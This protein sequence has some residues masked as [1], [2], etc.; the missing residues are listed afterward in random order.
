MASTLQIASHIGLWTIMI[1]LYA[2]VYLLYRHVALQ[3]ASTHRDN[4][5][6]L[7][8]P[9]RFNLKTIDGTM[10]PLGN[11]SKPHVLFFGEQRCATCTKMEPFLR[12]LSHSHP[13]ITLVVVYSGDTGAAREFTAQMTNDVRVIAD[14]T[15]ELRHMWQIHAVPFA[16]VTDHSGRIRH[17]GVASTK[18]QIEAAFGAANQVTTAAG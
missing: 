1:V 8:E 16:V 14:P 12:N 6:S 7:N 9:L 4:G 13:Q 11:I 10:Y 5:P 18:K 3:Q 15:G 17:K 2:A